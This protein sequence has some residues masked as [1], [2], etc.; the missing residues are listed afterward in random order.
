MTIA[1]HLV[2]TPASCSLSLQQGAYT[3]GPG[4][5]QPAG[6]QP[7]KFKPIK[8]DGFHSSASDKA[9]QLR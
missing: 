1:S 7:G 6:E 4:P 5:H 3:P 8:A 9:L 2:V